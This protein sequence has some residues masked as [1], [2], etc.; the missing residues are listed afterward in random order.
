MGFLG[1]LANLLTRA[2]RDDNRLLH[3]MA[4]AEAK[5]PDKAVEIYDLLLA[6]KTTSTVRARALFNRALAHSALKEDGKAIADLEQ[7]VSM[8]ATPENVLNAARTQLARVRN[9]ID[10]QGHK[11]A[12][13]G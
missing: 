11:V 5:R 12:A 13:N 3:G 2:G 7:V 10:R 8:P 9:R 6:R 1:Q 4:Y